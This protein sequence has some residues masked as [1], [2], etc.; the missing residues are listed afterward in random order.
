MPTAGLPIGSSRSE[1]AP[2][3]RRALERKLLTGANGANW[4]QQWNTKVA[5]TPLHPYP[6]SIVML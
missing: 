3:D 2:G 6:A 1:A 4:R 5:V